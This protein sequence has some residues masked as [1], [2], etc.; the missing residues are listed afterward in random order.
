MKISDEKYEKSFLRSSSD[1]YWPSAPFFGGLS[2]FSLLSRF[3]FDSMAIL[4][5]DEDEVL[6]VFG[7]SV[8][9]D[10]SFADNGGTPAVPYET[11]FRFCDD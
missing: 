7:P 1:F 6:A 5:G 10:D 4:I 8:F 11:E 3:E 9:F 2:I